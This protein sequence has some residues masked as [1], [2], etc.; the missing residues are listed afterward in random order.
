MVINFDNIEGYC[1]LI[2]YSMYLLGLVV[3][4]IIEL[5]EICEINE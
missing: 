5:L 4:V 1:V 2:K 3:L